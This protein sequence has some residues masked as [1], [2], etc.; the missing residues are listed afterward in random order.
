MVTTPQ[1]DSIWGF[2]TMTGRTSQRLTGPL[3][4]AYFMSI[5]S[6]TL[7]DRPGVLLPVADSDF[8][9]GGYNIGA[10]DSTILDSNSLF[11]ATTY[12]HGKGQTE[13]QGSYHWGGVTDNDSMMFAMGVGFNAPYTSTT[14]HWL[15]SYDLPDDKADSVDLTFICRDYDIVAS[16]GL[17]L[18]NIASNGW[19]TMHW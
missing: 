15:S 4:F 19:R 10:K 13:Q 12:Y 6:V 16:N 8:T 14:R 7:N 3:Q 11:T 5:D 2:V 9:W 18:S 1:T 17:L